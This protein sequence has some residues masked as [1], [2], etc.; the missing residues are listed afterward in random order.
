MGNSSLAQ[1]ASECPR[2]WRAFLQKTLYDEVSPRTPMEVLNEGVSLRF[3]TVYRMHIVG[4][5][6]IQLL[7]GGPEIKY[8]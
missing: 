3:Q 1:E 6:C 4:T 8:L 7:Q 2:V 5:R